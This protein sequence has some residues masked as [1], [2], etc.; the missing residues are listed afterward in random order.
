M[1]VLHV[2]VWL[3]KAFHWQCIGVYITVAYLCAIQTNIQL[4]INNMKQNNVYI[5]T[6]IITEI[7]KQVYDNARKLGK[8]TNVDWS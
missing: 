1:N 5:H 7:S 4:I 6:E 3:V 8:I 2:H